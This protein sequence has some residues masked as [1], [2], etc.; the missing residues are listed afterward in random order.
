[1]KS[2][3]F[4][5]VCIRIDCISF[6]CHKIILAC[7]SEFFERLFQED[8]E[9]FL[10]D[11]TTP[12]VFQIFLDFIY[13]PNDDQF[14]NLEPDVLMCLLKC[15]N[16]WLAVEIEERCID[17]LLDL[18]PDMDPDAL[19]AL[20]AVS[21]C[22][23][24]KVLMEQSI[25]VLQHI[26]RNEMDC[27]ST[28]RMEVDC[29]GE[30]FKNTSG[31]LSPRRRFVMVENWIK[32]NDLNNRPCSQKDKINQIIKSINF[33]EMSLEDFY[34]GPGK[35]NVLPDSDKFEIMYKLARSNNEWTVILDERDRDRYSLHNCFGEEE[36]D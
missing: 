28:V 6:R 13:A 24:H 7:A 16:M 2:G 23:D 36:V 27:P 19:I 33:L 31:M 11:G 5:D 1:M 14:G 12:E 35:S 21:H 3:H 4:S 32:G 34:N 8:S 25:G 18:S 22:V 17:I 9:E 15:A 30:Y 10:L 26:W 20:F 29:F